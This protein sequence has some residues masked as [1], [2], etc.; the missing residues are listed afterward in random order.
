MNPR[1][2]ELAFICGLGC[3]VEEGNENLKPR[4]WWRSQG[5]C[6]LHSETFQRYRAK[7]HETP[8]LDREKLGPSSSNGFQL[9]IG[10]DLPHY[11]HVDV[12][13]PIPLSSLY[14]LSIVACSYM[15]DPLALI[16]GGVLRLLI[17]GIIINMALKH[18]TSGSRGYWRFV[19]S[20]WQCQ[21]RIPHHVVVRP[22]RIE[23]TTAVE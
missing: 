2:P 9:I 10:S 14:T 5:C 4:I 22:S 20:E 19:V 1:Y 16:Q 12:A 21:R 17:L 8:P 11:Y 18:E 7:N 15:T 13:L 3:W 6:P 23:P